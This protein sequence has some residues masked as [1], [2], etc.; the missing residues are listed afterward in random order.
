MN[1]E[2]PDSI[3]ITISA[4]YLK[5]RGCRKWYKD[6]LRGTSEEGFSYWIRIAQMPK[7]TD[8]L[9]VYL[10][11]GNRIRY[12]TNLVGFYPGSTETFFDGDTI[13]AKV[14]CVVTGPV[15]KG[16]IKRK[17]FQGFRYAGE[18]F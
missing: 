10:C 9:Y 12:R 14:W 3:I 7:F 17:G 15:V 1:M 5:E 8:L 13:T 18:L 11:I 6:F 2:R 16:D 4:E